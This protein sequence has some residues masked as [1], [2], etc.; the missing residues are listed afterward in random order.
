MFESCNLSL[1]RSFQVCILPTMFTSSSKPC[2]RKMLTRTHCHIYRCLCHRISRSP[3]FVPK[4]FSFSSLIFIKLVDS[5]RPVSPF[6]RHLWQHVAPPEYGVFLHR[7]CWC[8][9]RHSVSL[10]S[11]LTW[12]TQTAASLARDATDSFVV[13]AWH[14]SMWEYASNPFDGGDSYFTRAGD[15]KNE[16]QFDW[17]H[18][19]YK[20]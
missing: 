4:W 10:S 13:T 17:L 12:T 5:M 11:F 7:L 15:A 14:E 18:E 20:H 2:L 3:A 9:A 1:N 19:S 16:S 8:I 6:P